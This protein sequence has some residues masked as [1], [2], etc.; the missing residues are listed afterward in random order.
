[1]LLII[2]TRYSPHLSSLDM[3][4]NLI[5]KISVD[6]VNLTLTLWEGYHPQ[7]PSNN[8]ARSAEMPT[9]KHRDL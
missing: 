1:M 5:Y 4:S 7:L 2:K 8:M 3:H 9:Y 6:T